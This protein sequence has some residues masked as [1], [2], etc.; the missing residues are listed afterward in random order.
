MRSWKNWLS[1]MICGFMDAL[2][3]DLGGIGLMLLSDREYGVYYLILFGVIF[4]FLKLYFLIDSSAKMMLKKIAFST[5]LGMIVF[6]L[7][8]LSPLYSFIYEAV[9]ASPIAEDDFGQGLASVFVIGGLL[10]QRIFDL[11]LCLL[12]RLNKGN[13]LLRL[14]GKGEKKP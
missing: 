4:Y 9:F 8:I 13:W 12:I 14:F 11:I 7:L 10:L 3:A 2:M 1:V 6:V 5:I